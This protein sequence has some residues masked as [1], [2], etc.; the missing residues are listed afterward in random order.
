[1]VGAVSGPYRGK[2]RNG[3]H[4]FLVGPGRSRLGCSKRERWYYS[5]ID[6]VMIRVW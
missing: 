4:T 6:G 2:V 1:M 3:P 5:E